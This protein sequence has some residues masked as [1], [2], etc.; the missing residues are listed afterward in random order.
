MTD[1]MQLSSI[2]T[3]LI[4]TFA[5][6]LAAEGAAEASARTYN[7]IN[8]NISKM[9]AARQAAEYESL[10]ATAALQA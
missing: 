8:T 10:T 4:S 2:P 3:S 6:G 5:L 7:N 9:H 1:F